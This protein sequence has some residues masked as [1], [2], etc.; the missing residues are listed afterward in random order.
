MFFINVYFG[1]G[2]TLLFRAGMKAAKRTCPK[3][4]TPP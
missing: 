1:G 3:G 2:N 4:D